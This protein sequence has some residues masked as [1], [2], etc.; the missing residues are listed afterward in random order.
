MLKKTFWHW[1]VCALAAALLLAPKAAHAQQGF[2]VLTGT[3]VDAAAHQ[4][5]TYEAL[6]SPFAPGAGERS[7]KTGRLLAHRVR[8]IGMTRSGDG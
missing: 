3:I 6:A 2:A 1:V 7:A 8:T 4:A 5:G